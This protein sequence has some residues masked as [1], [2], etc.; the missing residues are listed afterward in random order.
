MAKPALD[1]GVPETSGLMGLT[2]KEPPREGLGGWNRKG[3][4]VLT[5]GWAVNITPAHFWSP[6]GAEPGALR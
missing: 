3:G 4:P 6:M 5:R 2:G 1:Q